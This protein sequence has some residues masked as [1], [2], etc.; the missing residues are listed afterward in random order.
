MSSL[1]QKI[2]DDTK[3]AMKAKDMVKVNILRFLTSAV[4]NREIEV[5]PNAL[6]DDDVI[7]VI[8]KSAKQRQDSIEQFSKAGRNDLAD[9]EKNELSIIET[10][11]PQQMS[12]DQVQKIVVEAIKESGATS[13][14]DMGAVMKLVIAK[15]QGTADNKLV[16]ELVRK[17]LQP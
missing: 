5:R 4:K 12:A 3:E 9:Q 11:L 2:L 13:A 7:S 8:K 6:T 17:Q 1:K 10:Y 15:T 14:K 16:S